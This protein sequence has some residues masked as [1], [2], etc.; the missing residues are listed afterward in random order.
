MKEL[1]ILRHA[2]S[3]W[4]EPG[5]SDFE[6][7]LNE[8]GKR[9]APRMG[10]LLREQ[11]LLPDLVISSDAKRA[12]KTA[13]AVCKEAGYAGPIEERHEFYLAEAGV[14]MAVLHD[15]PDAAGR[16][17]I[18]GHNPGLAFLVA[19]LTHQHEEMPTGALAHI[20]FPIR[21][22]R[23]LQLSTPGMLKCVWRPK[24]LPGGA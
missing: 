14:Y 12:I 9:D 8:R 1:L 18:V 21:H 22:W 19:S 5:L 2:K 15:A 10:R 24:E 11:D 6:R 16:I 7:P 20:V 4:E 13:R 17:L 3:S 23:E